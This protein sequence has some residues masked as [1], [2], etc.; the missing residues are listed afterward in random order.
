MSRPLKRIL[1]IIGGAVGL[2]VLVALA[3]PLILGANRYKPQLEAAA[4]DA[5]GMDVRVGGRLSMGFFPG[6]HVTMEDGRILGEQGVV[7]ASAKRVRL[8]VDLLPL[9]RK[10]LRLRRIELTQ[11]TLS[12]ERDAEGRYNVERLKKAVALLGALDG[13]SVSL[14]DG[15]L[16]FADRRSGKGIKATDLDLV[17]SRVRVAGGRSSQL[18]KGLSFKAE[19]NCGEVR[20]KDLSVSALK[21]LVDGKDGVFQLNPVTMSVFGGH[22]EGSIRADVTGPVPIYLVHYSLPGFRIEE[23]LKA[24]S[25]TK[26]AEGGMDFS[27]NLSMR[28]NTSR[29]LVESA[30]GDFSLRGGDLTL[31]GHDLDGEIS[32][33]ESSQNFSLVDVGAVFLAGPV[34][35]AVTKGYNFASLFQG[36]GGT[37]RIGA[38]V[39]DWRIEHGV[40]QATDVALATA[41]NRIALQGGLDFVSGRFADMTVAV[42]DAE[43]CATV[44]QAIRGPFGKPEVEKPHVLK[45]LTGPMRKLYRKARG[46]FPS[47][48]CEVFYSGSVAPPK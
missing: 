16:L 33:F 19:L 3:V 4:S 9:L 20:T 45:S 24:L 31:V 12:I 8:F 2:L 34:G 15:T 29:Q 27:A 26:A 7:V 43:G 36:S 41:E 30:A 25:P 22:S 38:L 23:F 18:L 39:S 35:L 17:V 42:V 28:G 21:V 6:L 48:P 40:A 46:L 5:L 47:G 37:T 10:E 44:R 14:S 13:A 1:F 11:P 32:R